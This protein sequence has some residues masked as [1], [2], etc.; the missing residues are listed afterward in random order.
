M[1]SPARV[2]FTDGVVTGRG[3]RASVGI[4]EALVVGSPFGI[5]MGHC[6]GSTDG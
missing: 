4:E 2:M 6:M 5:E 3:V 1:C